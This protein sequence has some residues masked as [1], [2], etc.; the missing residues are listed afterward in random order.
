MR[1]AKLAAA[2]AA[3]KRQSGVEPPF[4]LA[5]MTDAARAPHPLLVA[6]TLPKGAAVILRDYMMRG[7]AGLAVQLKSVCSARGVKLIIGADVELAQKIDA[8]G[9]HLPRWFSPSMPIPDNMIVTASAHDADELRRAKEMGADLAFLSPAL[10]TGSH[11]GA[12]S[13]GAAA[14]KRLA[15]ASPLPVLAL[16]GVNETNARLIAGPNVAGLAAISAFVR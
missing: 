12:E 4:S 8:D 6:R 11:P 13:L 5:F 3:L 15:A 16:G 14:F 1:A 9:V 10:P 7:R 2:A